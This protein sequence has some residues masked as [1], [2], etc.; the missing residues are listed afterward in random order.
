M[1]VFAVS[2]L[3]FCE[4]QASQCYTSRKGIS[5]AIVIAGAFGYSISTAFAKQLPHGLAGDR[6]PSKRHMASVELH[7]S[8][9][10]PYL[11]ASGSG[12]NSGWFGFARRQKLAEG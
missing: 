2:S 4:H 3:L 6:R 8:S 1:S 9:S 7:R 12:L 11:A 5:T 10:A